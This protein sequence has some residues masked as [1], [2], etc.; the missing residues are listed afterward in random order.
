MAAMSRKAYPTD[1]TDGQWEQ[2]EPL[3]PKAKSGIPKGGR[4]VTVE[5]RDVVDAIF[6]H[7][8]AG[9]AWRM[10]PHDFPAWQTVYGKFRDWRLDGTWEKVHAAL[11]EKVRI[12]AGVPPTPETLR[13]DSQTVK[14]TH[15]G[16]PK[17]YDGGKKVRGRKRFIG[18]DSLG[19]VWALSVVTAD[20]QD[21]DGGGGSW[22]RCV[23]C[24]RGC[25]R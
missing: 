12:D 14:T 17:G 1:L 11:R 24:C 4:P 8:R 10:M 22:A 23:T 2:L 20:V 13:V 21:R 19:L 16:G 25:V 5:L 18:V 7:L 3:L 15:R 6:Y 9:G